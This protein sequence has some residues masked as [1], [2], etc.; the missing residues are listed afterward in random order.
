VDDVC[1]FF[2]ESSLLRRIDFYLDGLSQ[3]NDV[4]VYL[5]N[6]QG[7]SDTQVLFFSIDRRLEFKNFR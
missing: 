1:R 3:A 2:I 7:L 6:I 4:K 5:K